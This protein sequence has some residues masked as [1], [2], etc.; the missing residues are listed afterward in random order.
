MLVCFFLRRRRQYPKKIVIRLV[1]YLRDLRDERRNCEAQRKKIPAF[2]R[3]C[4]KKGFKENA[5]HKI[6][7]QNVVPLVY[8]DNNIEEQRT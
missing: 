2:T 1:I 8:R 3:N 6:L 4:T 5:C 7:H